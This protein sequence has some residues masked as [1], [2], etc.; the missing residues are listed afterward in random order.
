MTDTKKDPRVARAEGYGLN[1]EGINT[2]PDAGQAQVQAKAD[3]VEALGY[4]PS[5][6]AS[7]GFDELGEEVASVKDLEEGQKEYAKQFT[8][9]PDGQAAEKPTPPHSAEAASSG[10]TDASDDG[11]PVKSASR[12]EWDDYARSQGDDPEQ[13]STK[14]DLQ[15]H[16]GV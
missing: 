4:I 8:M 2:D 14:E 15:A 7:L 3:R 10:T 12:E 6:G 11:R 9:P 5:D 1:A 13:F 16:Y